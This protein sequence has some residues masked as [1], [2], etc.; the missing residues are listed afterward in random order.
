MMKPTWLIVADNSMARIF[1]TNM[2]KGPIDEVESISH[3]EARLHEQE[4]T[5]DLPGRSNGKG[6]AG[7]HAY[8]DETSPKEQEDLNFARKI[9]NHLD[10]ARK[11]SKFKQLIL[12]AAPGF[13]GNL[14][15][16]LTPQTKNLVSFELDK[17]LAHLSPDEIRRH[18]P[19]RLPGS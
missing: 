16:L 10:S 8:A 4:L 9:A 7:R 17:N 5:S 11:S 18:L 14:R 15:N 12:V 1:S 2:H 3:D 13:L 19:E 6:G